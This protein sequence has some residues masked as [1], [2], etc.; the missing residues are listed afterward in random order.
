M[1]SSENDSHQQFRI[2]DR[3]YLILEE[4]GWISNQVLFRREYPGS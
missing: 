1:Q 4:I 3:K 2:P